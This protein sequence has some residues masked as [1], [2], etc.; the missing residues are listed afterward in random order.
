VSS[1]FCK[2]RFFASCGNSVARFPFEV[3]P[4]KQKKLFATFNVGR[5][6]F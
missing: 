5:L 2:P 4:D 1:A 3:N 6:F